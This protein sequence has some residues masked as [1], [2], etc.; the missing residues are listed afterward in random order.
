MD[1]SK[2]HITFSLIIDIKFLVSII[3]MSNKKGTKRSN[4]LLQLEES[5]LDNDNVGSS[6]IRRSTRDPNG[7]LLEKV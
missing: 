7:S 2:F 4:Q 5:E 3:N 6:D 1:F